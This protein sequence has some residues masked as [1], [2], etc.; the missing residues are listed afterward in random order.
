MITDFDN[1]KKELI[2]SCKMLM[3]SDDDEQAAKATD[4]TVEKYYERLEEAKDSEDRRVFQ[5]LFRLFSNEPDDG[6]LESCLSH[7][8]DMGIKNPKLFL[9]V[10]LEELPYLV[11]HVPFWAF[12]SLCIAIKLQGFCEI[13]RAATEE[14]KAL[15]RKVAACEEDPESA[16]Q[17]PD[18]D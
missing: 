6:I 15:I 5:V 11:E 7:L 8:Y 9:E 13:F 17:L 10:F 12:S 1:W 2:Q 18:V 3:A 16:V 4:V 14:Q